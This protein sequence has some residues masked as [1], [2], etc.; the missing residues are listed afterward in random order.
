MNHLLTLLLSPLFIPIYLYTWPTSYQRWNFILPLHALLWLKLWMQLSRW[1]FIHDLVIMGAC[2]SGW[3][4]G[5]CWFTLA[6]GTS[7]SFCGWDGFP[8]PCLYYI[9]CFSSLPNLQ[10]ER[11]NGSIE[12]GWA[13]D[14]FYDTFLL[15]EKLNGE[16]ER[17]FFSTR[18]LLKKSQLKF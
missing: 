10:F 18:F 1:N 15:F 16:L 17:L 7:W 6:T 4:A 14:L 9:Q 2:S 8:S 5:G 13:S 12:I 3:C 11:M